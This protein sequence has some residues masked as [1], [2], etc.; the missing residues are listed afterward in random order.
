ML[1][2]RLD[3]RWADEAANAVGEIGVDLSNNPEGRVVLEEILFL[4]ACACTRSS[5][6]TP[7]RLPTSCFGS[8]WT[9]IG[10]LRF[11]QSG[12]RNLEST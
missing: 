9:V 12:V 3:P 2:E 4:A 11:K 8:S 10:G 5:G 7:V 6:R 1:G